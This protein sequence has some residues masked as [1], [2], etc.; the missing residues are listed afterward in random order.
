MTVNP[1]ESAT[2]WHL[3]VVVILITV[4]Y[5]AV[6]LSHACAGEEYMR[7][8]HTQ[9][10]FLIG[11]DH[12]IPC[13]GAKEDICKSVRDQMLSLPAPSPLSGLVTSLPC[14]YLPIDSAMLDPKPT[15]VALARSGNRLAQTM[16]QPLFLSQ[17]TL[18]I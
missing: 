13:A 6:T 3:I 15:L 14:A 4:S 11:V 8:P 1:C 2:K 17:L 12:E 10:T 7:R 5:L 9:E 16:S 18:R